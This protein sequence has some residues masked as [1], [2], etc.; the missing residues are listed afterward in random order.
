MRAGF[1]VSTGH[2]AS[3][4]RYETT[5]PR[6]ENKRVGNCGNRAMRGSL[7][8]TNRDQNGH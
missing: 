7:E 4:D 3:V 6:R 8:N 2:S 5:L 1:E